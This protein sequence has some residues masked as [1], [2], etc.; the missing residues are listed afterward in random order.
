M[1]KFDFSRFLDVARWDLYINRQAYVK[2]TSMV[3]GVYVLIAMYTYVTS[4]LGSNG[5]DLVGYAFNDRLWDI[6]Y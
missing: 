3:V 4:Y 2:Y 1:K 6:Y 5:N